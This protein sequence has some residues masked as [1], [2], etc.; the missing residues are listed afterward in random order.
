M[1]DFAAEQDALAKRCWQFI[2][3]RE[4]W[5]APDSWL[6]R[7]LFNR[8]VFIQ[9]FGDELR[10]YAN[11]CQHRG[12]PLRTEDSGQG[13]VQCGFHGWQY[14]RDGVPT[15]VPRNPELFQ[16]SQEAKA[17]LRLPAVRVESIGNLVFATT[18][19]EAPPLV[20]YLDDLADVFRTVD[21]DRGPMYAHHHFELA[22]NW[23]LHAEITLDDYHLAGVHPTTFGVN[24][25]LAVEGHVY[26]QHGPHS[27]YLW[28]KDAWWDFAPWWE[29]MRRGQNV[30]EG[31]KIFNAFP[32]A[33]IATFREGSFSSV[34]TPLSATRTRI[35]WFLWDWHDTNATPEM[36]QAL[37]DWNFKVGPE[38]AGACERWQQ[39]V[40][41]FDRP[42]L[43]GKLEQRCAWFRDAY[44]RLMR[45]QPST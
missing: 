33:L 39:A 11:I 10:G 3:P 13:L 29:K 25:N 5:P 36:H 41:L 44:G 6:R 18:S 28:R 2:G 20:D 27:S 17:A 4:L 7:T 30:R 15:G 31:Y 45:S 35:D 26:E 40:D 12:F 23:K 21:A 1:I 32:A 16:L 38:D 9:R 43:F 24:P 14:N 8:D 19:D 22:A 34:A 42:P 37:I